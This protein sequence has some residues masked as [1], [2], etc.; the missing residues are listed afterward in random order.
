MRPQGRMR[1]RAGPILTKPP[2]FT[3]LPNF[4]PNSPAPSAAVNGASGMANEVT[5]LRQL[6]AAYR[7]GHVPTKDFVKT[8]EYLLSSIEV[9][10]EP[11]SPDP[12]VWHIVLALF[13]AVICCTG[14]TAWV[15]QDLTLALTLTATLMAAV[16]VRAL[17]KTEG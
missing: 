12:N 11:P 8:R 3:A 13:V 16:A 17:N 15:F 4:R 1:S 14:F 6:E 7:R 2:E 10:I 5:E 9:V